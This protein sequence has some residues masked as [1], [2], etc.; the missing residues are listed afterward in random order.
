MPAVRRGSHQSPSSSSGDRPL[1]EGTVAQ[2]VRGNCDRQEI[3]CVRNA[4]GDEPVAWAAGWPTTV[5]L[6]GVLYCHASPGDDMRPILTEASPQERFDE[7]L[8]GVDNRLVVAGHTYM[9]PPRTEVPGPRRGSGR[10]AFWFGVCFD[11]CCALP[12]LFV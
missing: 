1:Y 7:A 4:L 11:W 10:L 6:D 8:A 5:E 9:P 2:F 12:G 3:E